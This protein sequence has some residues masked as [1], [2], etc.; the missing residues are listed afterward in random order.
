[1]RV[2]T[3]STFVVLNVVQSQALKERKVEVIRFA[4][5][6]DYLALEDA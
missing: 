4:F 1:M 3:T 6:D 2:D 5:T